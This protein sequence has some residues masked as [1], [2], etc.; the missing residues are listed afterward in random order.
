M[1]KTHESKNVNTPEAIT[2]S[3]KED[4]VFYAWMGMPK[5]LIDCLPPRIMYK[6]STIAKYQQGFGD[7]NHNGL[8][9]IWRSKHKGRN[10][11]MLRKEVGGSY[12]LLKH[13]IVALR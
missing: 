7:P 5:D 2:K 3:L 4:D 11:K 8:K 9:F 13:I 12:L 1:P 10:R 6:H